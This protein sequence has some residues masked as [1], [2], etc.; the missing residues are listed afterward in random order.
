MPRAR[1]EERHISE[2]KSVSVKLPVQPFV[3][4]GKVIRADCDEQVCSVTIGLPSVPH[5]VETAILM[6]SDIVLDPPPQVP[7]LP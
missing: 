3:L 1:L 4:T 7:P 5:G 2:G 6:S